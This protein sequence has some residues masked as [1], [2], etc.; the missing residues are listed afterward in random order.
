[1]SDDKSNVGARD[2]ATVSGSEDYEVNNFAQKHGISAEQARQ[3]IA[4]H[5]NN[6]AQLDESAA[7][8][9]RRLR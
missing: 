2:R 7:S 3:L 1:M 9:S 4:E 6:R 5:G 8:L